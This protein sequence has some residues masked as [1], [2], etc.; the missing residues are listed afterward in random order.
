LLICGATNLSIR[1]KKPKEKPMSNRK[2][3]DKIIELRNVTKE[4]DGVTAV[5]DANISIRRGE[6]VTLLGPSGCGKTTILRMIAGFDQPTKGAIIFSGKDIT[7]TPPQKRPV[8]TVFQ[9]YALFPHLTVF[10]NVAYGLKLKKIPAG[11][12]KNKDGSVKQL[13][14]KYTKRE[15]TEQVSAALR[16]VNLEDYGHRHVDT[17]SG[18]Q[19][20]RVAL[21]RALV[22]KPEVLL[23]DEPLSALDLKMRK[24]M[25]LEL[26][27]MH[28]ELGITFI[29]V[30][31]DQEE[32]LTMS[33]TVVVMNDGVIQQVGSPQKIYDEPENAFVANFIGESNILSAVMA[34]DYRVNI[35]GKTLECVDKGFAKNEPVDIVIRPEDLY[36]VPTDNPKALF[37]GT[38]IS[39]VFKGEHYDMTVL[40]EGYE[41][42]V[43]EFNGSPVGKEVGLYI[44]PDGIHIMKKQRIINEFKTEYSD[45][46]VEISGFSVAVIPDENLECKKVLA[47]F[48]FDDA[49]LTDDEE[50]G[51][52]RGN[53]FSA[54]YKGRYYQV[55]VKTDDDEDIFV[56]T[57]YEWD[58]NDRVG[59][60]IASEK[61]KLTVLEEEE[62]E[63]QGE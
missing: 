32:A 55:V 16:L 12:K 30:T 3:F 56:N 27:K 48:E 24:E 36:L 34:E 10:G 39:G 33:D 5:D 23:L 26:K 15:L 41:F 61:I 63:E 1:N 46:C 6:F 18:G 35:L 9:R 60:N 19:Q 7:D 8:N 51:A 2:T 14:R 53:I 57:P 45:G 28:S 22:I 25:Q 52:I 44:P 54:L 49:V 29:F 11:E 50:D 4:F 58:L 13:F 62:E 42:S 43:T 47:S 37:I 59:I 21:A 17:L 20:Q 40:A 31:H 38:V